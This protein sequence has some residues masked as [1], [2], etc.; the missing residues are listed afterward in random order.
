MKLY[1]PIGIILLSFLLLSQSL[2]ADVDE[3]WSFEGIPD[4]IER[5]SVV[6][7]EDLAEAERSLLPGQ[8]T[9]VPQRSI[10]FELPIE[11]I[12]V[13]ATFTLEEL[14]EEETTR[15][16]LVASPAPTISFRALDDSLT[17]IPPDTMGAVGLNHLMTTLNDR[18]RIQSKTGIILR[19]VSLRNFWGVSSST[20]VFDPKITY[21]PFENRW[22][23]TALINPRRSS[24]SI[25]L[26]VSQTSDPLGAWNIY[27]ILADSGLWADFPSLG[28]NGKWIV[29]QANM[30]NISN[31]AF[32][33]SNVYVFSK[34]DLYDG[35]SAAFRLFPLVNLGATHVPAITLDPLHPTLYLLQNWNGNAGGRGYLALY[36]IDGTVGSETLVRRG[37]VSVAAPWGSTHP[38]INGGFAPQLNTPRR[39]MNNDARMQSVMFRNGSLWAAQT[40]FLPASSPTHSAIQWWQIN[41]LGVVEQFARI[42]DPLATAVSG[43]FFAF[44]SIAVN[45]FNDVLIG[46]SFFSASRYA[47]S[48]YS[49]RSFTDLPNTMRGLTLLKDGTDIYTKDFGSGRVRWGDYSAT[50]ADPDGVSFWTIQES[51]DARTSTNV[52]RWDT[53]WARV[54]PLPIS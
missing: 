54:M 12:D 40:V 15:Q 5:Q 17:V 49:F 1:N 43:T 19:T 25:M 23:F 51:A 46:Y 21:D 32:N 2:R 34:A 30:F 35:G 44:P 26:A 13:I 29:V 41:P 38:I 47:S 16:P 18:V 50:A 36:I 39:I 42:E 37:L 48:G 8:K 28:F 31:N 33:R 22:I 53:W 4:C 9:V 14:E 11:G 7:V 10:P 52:T 3:T 20:T 24:S 45:S 27:S 6:C